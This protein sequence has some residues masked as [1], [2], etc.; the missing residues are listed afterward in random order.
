MPQ[1]PSESVELGLMA[2]EVGT[3]T[4]GTHGWMAELTFQISK[5]HSL[6]APALSLFF[7]MLRERK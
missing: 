2:R 4:W 1:T 5:L 6:D 3:N 7:S